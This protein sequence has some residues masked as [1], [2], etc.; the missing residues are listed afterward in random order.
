MA[1]RRRTTVAAR[2]A[3]QP[4]GR[5]PRPVHLPASEGGHGLL[6][7]PT[8]SGH[9]RAKHAKRQRPQNSR[10]AGSIPGRFLDRRD[11][12]VQLAAKLKTYAGGQDVLVL[13]LPRG[14]TPVGY[15]VARALGAEL[16]VLVVRK[17]GLP[18]QPELAMGAIASGG[19]RYLNEA[20][21]QDAGISKT[22]L[23]AVESLERLELE[24]RERLY[25]GTRPAPRVRGRTIIVVDDGLAT[26]ASMRAALMA[27][28]S[29]APA[30]L[31]AAVPV[32][33][34]DAARRLGNAAD[35]FVCVEGPRRFQSVGDFY[36]E[37][38]QIPDAEVR[39]LLERAYAAPA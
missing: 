29:L 27:V 12:G 32:A 31:V 7:R 24:R 19:A 28:R 5:T 2:H 4:V 18:Q 23:R 15:E 21:L 38:G 6:Q 34:A 26:G 35:D 10:E 22:M 16:D 11:A 37:F 8:A 20:V 13:S 39:A 33:P 9:R 30:R 1:G 25:R 17:L 36:H 14:G 3:T